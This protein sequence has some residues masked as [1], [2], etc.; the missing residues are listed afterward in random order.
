VRALVLREI[1][2]DTLLG[3]QWDALVEQME[4]PEVFY[5]YEWAIS[6]QRA[7][8]AVLRP[9]LLLGY[10]QGSLI[11]VAALAIKPKDEIG[12]LAESTGDYCDFLSAPGFRQQWCDAVLSELRSLGLGPVSLANLPAA[13][14]TASVLSEA[15][16]KHGYRTFAR[17]AYRCARIVLGGPE[18]RGVLQHR[19]VGKKAFRRNLRLLDQKGAAVFSATVGSD[20][21]DEVVTEF[22]RAHVTRFIADGR[23]SN[24]VQ[25]ERRVFLHELAQQLSKRGW[26]SL[27]RLLVGDRCV[28]WNYGFQ[29]GGSWFWYQPTFDPAYE[30]YSPGLCLLGKVIEAA[31]GNPRISVVDLGLGAEGYKERFANE[32]QP[33]LHI[34]LSSSPILHARSVLCHRVADAIKT[35]P[36]AERRVRAGLNRLTRLRSYLR[37]KG[38]RFSVRLLAGRVRGAALGESLRFFQWCG[39]VPVAQ[40]ESVDIR[41]LDANLLALA[42]IEYSDDQ[43]TLDYLLHGAERL[44]TGMARGFALL[45]SSGMPVH[46]C[47]V[48]KFEDLA[49]HGLNTW[50]GAP[51]PTVTAIF[52]SWSPKSMRR[53]NYF[54]IA[55]AAVASWV[56]SS[57]EA[58]W[59]FTAAQNHASVN[60]ILKAGFAYKFTIRRHFFSMR[61]TGKGADKPAVSPALAGNGLC[62]YVHSEN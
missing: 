41:E 28:A 31:C 34:R 48:S 18:D 1:P 47:W 23:L 57:G 43:G 7:Y 20:D 25:P 49:M 36:Q 2:D 10:D 3:E 30:R 29:F 39:R 27:N 58:P 15:A 32:S 13:S 19:A 26:L 59:I 55:M 22:C 56:F 38:W 9:L 14:E 6:V 46:F 45:T 16:R 42:A 17:P 24:M 40:D 54:P 51:G 60:D 37:E 33:T 11:G 4:Q 52:D 53:R 21:M 5:T 12:F 35:R 61:R 62:H 44:R 8:G 50:P